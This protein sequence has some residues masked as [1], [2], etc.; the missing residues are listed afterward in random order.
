M[1]VFEELLDYA[2][3]NVHDLVFFSPSSKYKVMS[4]NN[5]NKILGIVIQELNFTPISIHGLRHTHHASVLLPYIIY[6][7]G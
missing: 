4:N 2:P 7:N 3:A 6:P 1:K 5:S